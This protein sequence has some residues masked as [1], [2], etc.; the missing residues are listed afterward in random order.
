MS[1][2]PWGVASHSDKQLS[3]EA[4]TL[5]AMPAHPDVQ[6]GLA[7]ASAPR[8]LSDAAGKMSV[9]DVVPVRSLELS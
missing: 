7:S 4:R 3:P 5:P 1:G 2:V 8:V 9:S 6:T